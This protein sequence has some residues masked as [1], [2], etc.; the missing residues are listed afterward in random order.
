MARNTAEI[1]KEMTDAFMADPV[2][3]ERYQLKEGDT[4]RSAFSDVSLEN[5]LFFIVAGAHHIL[6][7]LFDGFQEDVERTLERSIVATVPWYYHQAL[8]YQHGDK[9]VLDEATM[10]YHYPTVDERR[11]VIKY[12][13]V[14][15][16]G[17]SIQILVSGQKDG[18]P[19]SLSKDVLTAFEAYIR[20]IKPAGVVISIRS[21]PADHVRISASISIDPLLISPEGVRYRDGSRPIEEAIHAYLRGITFGGTFN[22]TRLTDAI[23]AVEGVTDILLGDCFARTSTGDW[24]TIDGNNYTAFAGSLIA[25]EL[26]SSLRYVVSL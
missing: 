9:L 23:Q 25:D 18:L 1:K 5:L 12:V 20:T 10:R 24:R 16:L 7:R 21:A 14:R 6:E 17:G 26:T 22:K 3:R 13:A 4:F 15:D 2:I 11:Q 8:A 19:E